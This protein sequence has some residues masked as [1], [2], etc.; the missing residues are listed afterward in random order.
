MERRTRNPK[1]WLY[2]LAAAM[3]A[4]IT[5]S[6]QLIVLLVPHAP[7]HAMDPAGLAFVSKLQSYEKQAFRDYEFRHISESVINRSNELWDYHL[8]LRQTGLAQPCSSAVRVLSQMV[9]GAYY[10]SKRS[11]IPLDW[12][13]FAPQY[14]EYRSACLQALNAPAGS[15]ALP[16]SFAR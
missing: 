4:M 5:A 10:A 16:S 15:Y 11:E 14:G 12:F 13:H 7:A 2:R 1:H 8:E 3:L 6:A 9:S